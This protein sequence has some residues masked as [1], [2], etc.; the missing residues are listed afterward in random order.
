MTKKF[1]RYKV[2]ISV[3]SSTPCIYDGL[4]AE[5]AQDAGRIALQMLEKDRRAESYHSAF[6]NTVEEVKDGA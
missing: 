6:V 1:K 4:Y 5:C 3:I 2:T